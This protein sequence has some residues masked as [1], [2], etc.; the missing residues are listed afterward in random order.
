MLEELKFNEHTTYNLSIVRTLKKNKRKLP[1]EFTFPNRYPVHSSLFGF[2][3]S[4]TIV[5][6]IPK[7]YKVVNAI[8]IMHNDKKIDEDS[9][10]KM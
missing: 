2:Q 10:K 9:G 3:E 6:Y 4:A 5:S 7:K 8:S 1:T